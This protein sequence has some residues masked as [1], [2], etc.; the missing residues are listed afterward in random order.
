MKSM[1]KNHMLGIIDSSD[2]G[3]LHFKL[4]DV[5]WAEIDIWPPDV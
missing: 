1:S 3:A 4:T 2:G 5:V